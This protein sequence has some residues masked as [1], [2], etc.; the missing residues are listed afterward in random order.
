MTGGLEQKYNLKNIKNVK[1]I[2]IADFFGAVFLRTINFVSTT[3]NNNFN[4]QS[5][6]VY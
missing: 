3:L 2:Y 5:N 6:P 4:Q 1:E